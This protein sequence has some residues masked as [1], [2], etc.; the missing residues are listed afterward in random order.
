MSTASPPASDPDRPAPPPESPRGPEAW[1]VP[2]GSSCT[3][4]VVDD[5]ASS[6]MV[7]AATLQAHGYG[8]VQANGAEQALEKFMAHRPDVV[9]L[10]VE[11]PDHD[12][13]WV[14]RQMRAIEPDGWTP[15]IYLSGQSNEMN[16]W[17]GIDAGGDDYLVKPARPA[18][19]MAKLRSM[20]RLI[21]M[22]K[23]LLAVS[24][25]LS[26]ANE[27]LQGLSV[28]D[29]LTGLTNR[30]GLDQRLQQEIA[31]ARRDGTPLSIFLCD[32]DHFKLYNDTL[33][34][35][36]GDTCLKMIARVLMGVCKRP[37]DLAAR[38]GGEEFVL[39][40]P[41]TPRSGALTLGRTLLHMLRQQAIPH[42]KCSTGPWV[43]LSGGI[44]T[45]VPGES[46]T[47]EELLIRADEALYTAKGK[48]RNRFFS[49][50]LGVDATV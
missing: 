44:T 40:L 38:Y 28:N 22:R 41:N 11:M 25:E 12:G 33:G 35:G 34:H 16:L 29:A 8:V 50:E 20:Q 14:A 23:R 15:I 10:D 42:P 36:E 45:L 18:V 48:G 17:R 39:V 5:Q 21:S 37:R 1:R 3:V 9:L 2:E 46:C 7:V 19:L 47:P 32:V 24:V 4:L 49:Y 6:R 26:A 27:K 43:S 13:F 30:R 31:A